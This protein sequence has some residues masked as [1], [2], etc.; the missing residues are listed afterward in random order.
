[1]A[2]SADQQAQVDELKDLA[3]VGSLSDEQLWGII[4][5]EGS[6]NAAASR[7]WA[8]TAKETANLFDIKEGSSSRN[9]SSIHKQAVEMSKYFEEKAGA[10]AAVLTS[11]SRTRAI[12]RPT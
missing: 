7:L 12:V 5:V 4:D 3:N 11:G 2:L 6:V 1:M 8:K 10:D 9:M